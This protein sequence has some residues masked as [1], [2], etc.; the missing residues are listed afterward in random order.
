M[1]YFT[2][3]FSLCTILLFVGLVRQL[4]AQD[5]SLPPAK[6]GLTSIL[7][8]GPPAPGLYGFL[9]NQFYHA[10]SIRSSEGNKAASITLSSLLVMPHIALLAKKQFLGGSPGFQV[11]QPLVFVSSSGTVGTTANGQPVILTHNNKVN[12]DLLVG[13]VLQWFNKRLFGKPFVHRVELVFS[14]PTGA[15]DPRYIINPGSNFAT[16]TPLYAFTFFFTP[17]F[18]TSQRHNYTYSF[19]NPNSKM[20]SGQMYFGNYSLEYQV[21]GQLR[22]G[23][24]G[25]YLTQLTE[26]RSGGRKFGFN[27]KERVVGLGPAMFWA[28]KKGF[29]F[30]AKSTFETEA[31]N[32]TKGVRF[33]V[34]L[35]YKLA[36]SKPM[37]VKQQRDTPPSLG[38][39]AIQYLLFSKS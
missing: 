25:Y 29:V 36:G 8:G 9:Y 12:G 18:S 26:D 19:E 20:K 2:C 37:P 6:L 30:E 17:K 14:L 35:I 5:P 22:I 28:S 32:R 39:T 33:T 7:D 38:R 1:K 27:T 23:A 4:Y 16:V 11:L 15:Y 31:E 34:R 24:A 3:T 13:P 10:S 21:A